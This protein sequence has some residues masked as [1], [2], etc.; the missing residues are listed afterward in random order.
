MSDEELRE[1][2]GIKPN[3][4]LEDGAEREVSSQSRYYNATTQLDHD[5]HT[6]FFYL[7]TRYIK[8]SVLGITTTGMLC[9][10]ASNTLTSKRSL[11][12]HVRYVTL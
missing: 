3:V 5:V 7:V 12:V 2:N 4:W 11:L 1:I 9:N 6:L 10:V 8:L